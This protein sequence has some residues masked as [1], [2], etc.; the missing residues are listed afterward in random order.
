[1]SQVTVA[2][3]TGLSQAAV[4]E[5]ENTHPPNMLA[6]TMAA[7][8]GTLGITLDYAM[9]GQSSSQTAQEAELLALLR[10][11]PP[12]MRET[13]LRTLRAMLAPAEDGKRRAA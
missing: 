6:V 5:A 1:M 3:L 8:C 11:A 9:H 12:E 4:S 2:G 13:A 10:Q 7:L